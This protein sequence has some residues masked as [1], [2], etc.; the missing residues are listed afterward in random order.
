MSAERHNPDQD[1]NEAQLF[2][3][4]KWRHART[5]RRQLGRF[6]GIADSMAEEPMTEQAKGVDVYAVTD[7][8]DDVQAGNSRGETAEVLAEVVD[9]TDPE[10]AAAKELDAETEQVADAASE[11]IAEAGV[12][13]D[14][15]SVKKTTRERLVAD[16]AE[17]SAHGLV[18][19]EVDELTTDAGQA[20]AAD[21]I[22]ATEI[23][24]AIEDNEAQGLSE[25]TKT[26]LEAQLIDKDPDQMSNRQLAEAGKDAIEELKGVGVEETLRFTDEDYGNVIELRHNTA[27]ARDVR[28]VF[29]GQLKEV[30]LRWDQDDKDHLAFKLEDMKEKYGH[31]LNTALRQGRM[32]RK[33]FLLVE[34]IIDRAR[35]RDSERHFKNAA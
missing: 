6:A 2:D 18:S 34:S 15:T 12:D 30:T 29:A 32:A 13:V 31:D 19:T 26:D 24:Q 22:V 10:T 8:L 7:K 20:R 17:E 1:Q 23:A 28:R 16:A 9:V 11:A 4:E 25:K 27:A 5:R 3:L 35:D 21:A 14:V 33:D